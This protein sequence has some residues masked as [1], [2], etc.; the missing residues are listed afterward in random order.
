[1]NTTQATL[2]INYRGESVRVDPARITEDM[3]VPNIGHDGSLQADDLPGRA[4]AVLFH[5]AEGEGALI[6]PE[7][8]AVDCF[9][10]DDEDGGGFILVAYRADD[11]SVG[12]SCGWVDVASIT[13]GREDHRQDNDTNVVRAALEFMA[14][15][16]NTALKGS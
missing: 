16:I 5:T 13:R 6:T 12:V 7:G 2:T 11:R 9:A 3:F 14:E 15:Q 4:A 8:M 10:N 1:M